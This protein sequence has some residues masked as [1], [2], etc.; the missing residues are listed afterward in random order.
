[1]QYKIAASITDFPL[2]TSI[3]TF[4]KRFKE[5]GVDSAEL[6]LG[7]KTFNLQ[8]MVAL[9]KKSNLPIT[10]IHQSYWSGLGFSMDEY[11]IKQAKSLGIRT[12][13]F[14]PLTFA[15]FAST[16]MM[17]YFKQLQNI[18]KEYDVTI[19]LENMPKEGVYEKLFFPPSD[20]MV[21]QLEKM[22]E[23]AQEYDFSLTYDVS[24][25]RF[26]HPQEHA[27]FRKMLPRVKN[28]HLSSFQ[29]DQEHLP[30]D[31]GDFDTKTFLSYLKKENYTGLLTFEINYSLSKRLIIPYDFSEVVRSVALIKSLSGKSM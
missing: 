11:F 10:S 27:I 22:Y 25:T 13:T 24:H 5:A 19:C 6:V 4:F 20:T 18:Q 7:I 3:E 28:I 14:H 17:H 29:G 31:K 16:R 2:Q 15:S 1:M 26:T 30:L 8:S 9:S 23:I 21:S 12:F